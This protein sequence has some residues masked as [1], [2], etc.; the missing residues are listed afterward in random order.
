[1]SLTEKL[2]SFYSD[3]SVALIPLGQH[4]LF[5]ASIDMPPYTCFVD[6]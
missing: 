5:G 3:L 6:V 2:Q 4:P 1:M